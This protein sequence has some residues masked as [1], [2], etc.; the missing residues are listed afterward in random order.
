VDFSR[1]LIKQQ[2]AHYYS[3]TASKNIKTSG[4]RKRAR[5]IAFVRRSTDKDRTSSPKSRWN[6][7]QRSIEL[8]SSPPDRHRRLLRPAQKRTMTGVN[9]LRAKIMPPGNLFD[10]HL[11]DRKW[12][13]LILGRVKIRAW[14]MLKS[15]QRCSTAQK[16]QRET[17]PS[18]Q[19]T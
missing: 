17:L 4:D 10:H 12:N 8:P 19:R 1:L 11:L 6:R 5:I 14:D 15:H 2:R 13:G 3:S 9:R 16:R 7:C 18:K